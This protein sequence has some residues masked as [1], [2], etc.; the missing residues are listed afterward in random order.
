MGFIYAKTREDLVP[1]TKINSAES[2]LTGGNPGSVVCWG[3]PK[4]GEQYISLYFTYKER[5][6]GF[7]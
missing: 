2:R 3:M 6:W 1:C 5:L 4:M 7:L